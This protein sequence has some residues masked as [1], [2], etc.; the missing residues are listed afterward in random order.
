MEPST[1]TSLPAHNSIVSSS[2]TDINTPELP[3]P[4][5]SKEP[6]VDNRTSV[7]PTH[8]TGSASSAS[9]LSIHHMLNSENLQQ[10]QQQQQ[11]FPL[12]SVPPEQRDLSA[13]EALTQ[14]TR[15]ATLHRMLIPW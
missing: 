13:A 4:P 12:P 9:S 11:L 1:T 7:S 2:D 5:Y 3:P 14:L 8:R 15:S 6:I 10:Q